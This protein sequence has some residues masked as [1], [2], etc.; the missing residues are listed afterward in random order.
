MF[1]QSLTLCERHESSVI[2]YSS[3]STSFLMKAMHDMTVSVALS[4]LGGFQ[5]SKVEWF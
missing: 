5:S 1:S 3:P 4:H 2:L